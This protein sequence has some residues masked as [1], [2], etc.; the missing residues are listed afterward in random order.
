MPSVGLQVVW[1][2]VLSIP[3]ACIAWTVTHEEVFR[4]PR[5]Y[6][7]EQSKHAKNL[8]RFGSSSI[9]LHVNIASAIAWPFCSLSSPASDFSIPTGAG[10][11]LRYS[12]W[13]GLGTST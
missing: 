3:I 12:R 11:L 8:S 5:N 7:Q 2:L 13:F 9:Y 4:A 6:C 10:T 1:L